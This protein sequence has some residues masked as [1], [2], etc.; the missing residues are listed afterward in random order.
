M[1]AAADRMKIE[2][3]KAAV[4]YINNLDKPSKQRIKR[5]IEG[6]PGGDI[7]PLLGNA[8]LYR[9]RIGDWRIVFSYLDGNTVLIEKIGPRGGVYKGGSL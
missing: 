7:K 3:S 5:G 9:L 2:F 6:I 8:G 1:A 4:K